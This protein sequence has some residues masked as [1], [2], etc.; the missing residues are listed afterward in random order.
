VTWLTSSFRLCRAWAAW[1]QLCR[2]H[3]LNLGCTVVSIAYFDV[4]VGTPFGVRSLPM[5][6]VAPLIT[7]LVA[8]Q[9]LSSSDSALI[10]QTAQKAH[11]GVAAVRLLASLTIMT[12]GVAALSVRAGTLLL[13]LPLL[14]MA[15]GVL[16][17][18]AMNQLCWAALS[19]GFMA[20][21]PWVLSDA[22]ASQ[23]SQWSVDGRVAVL[24]GVAL[25]AASASYVCFGRARWRLA[26][27]IAAE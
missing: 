25:G 27:A 26:R 21:L 9:P 24:G 6:V 20:S 4:S 14:L 15:F 22:G 12:V 3:L 19:L 7:V 2:L 23:L 11:G 16:C 8:T 18:M 1:L 17:A 13:G 5:S 10:R